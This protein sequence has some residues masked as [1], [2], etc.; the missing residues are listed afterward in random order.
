M[1]DA[2]G[3]GPTG[4]LRDRP[5]ET[6]KTPLWPPET[7]K[8]PL[9]PLG[10]GCDA[11][12][13]GGAKEPP[14]GEPAVAGK[15]PLWPDG[16]GCGAAVVTV[17]LWPLG[18]L[19][20]WPLGTGCGAAVVT[21]VGG[22]ATAVGIA[23]IVRMRHA[24]LLSCSRIGPPGAAMP[25][26]MAL[27]WASKAA[28]LRLRMFSSSPPGLL[29][30]SSPSPPWRASRASLRALS[31]SAEASFARPAASLASRSAASM[32]R[33]ALDT[34][35]AVRDSRTS[36]R[37]VVCSALL[38]L[39]SA[40]LAA[41]I[42]FARSCVLP[43]SSAARSALR[44]LTSAWRRL[45]SAAAP[46]SFESF[47]PTDSSCAFSWWTSASRACSSAVRAPTLASSSLRSRS[48]RAEWSSECL[49]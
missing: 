23:L 26:P 24:P 14:M 44:R 41:S 28:H 10:T 12:R 27:T 33:C 48:M 43:A 15:S 22:A 49:L 37:R 42:C 1:S 17:R 29:S 34:C 8:I 2:A 18:T 25:M 13:A 36:R 38:R 9:R 30:T 21:R 7:G 40:A 35:S 46:P 6:G 47:A 45:F 5:P 20:L 32:R 11:F 3:P 16:T 4:A 19:R 39:A 31:R